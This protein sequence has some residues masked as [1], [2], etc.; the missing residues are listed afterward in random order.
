VKLHQDTFPTF[1]QVDVATTAAGAGSEEA[2]EWQA[3]PEQQVNAV[4]VHYDAGSAAAAISPGGFDQSVVAPA[5]A[6]TV[7]GIDIRFANWAGDA[8]VLHWP[9]DIHFGQ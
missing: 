2:H 9:A 5:G 8:V 6:N 7:T 1:F 4:T 3:Y